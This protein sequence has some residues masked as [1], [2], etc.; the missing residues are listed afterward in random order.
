MD[1]SI[2]LLIGITLVGTYAQVDEYEKAI[3]ELF[4]TPNTDFLT[5]YL[6]VT[7][8]ERNRGD[9]GALERC[10]QG[11]DE[12]VHLCVPYYN[13]DAE[14]KTIIP[15]EEYDGTGLIDIR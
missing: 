10:G 6:E 14:T 5:Q 11:K 12:G 7:T 1:K 13:C 8:T 15:S 3:A 9:I 4:T 2:L